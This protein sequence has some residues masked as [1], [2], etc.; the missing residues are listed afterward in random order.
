MWKLLRPL[1]ERGVAIPASPVPAGAQGCCLSLQSSAG[2]AP[3]ALQG[4][5]AITT[6]TGA[7]V[8]TIPVATSLALG[9][10]ASGKPTAIHQL[11][12]NGGL[13]KL[14]S[15]LPGLAQI[16]NQATGEQQGSVPKVPPDLG[17][18]LPEQPL[19]GEG[20]AWF[21]GGLSDIFCVLCR[22]EGPDHH[23]GDT[24]GTAWPCGHPEP[25]Q[26]EHSAAPAG[27]AAPGPS[28]K[29]DTFQG[30]PFL[31]SVTLLGVRAVLGAEQ[32]VS[33]ARAVSLLCLFRFDWP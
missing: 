7:V 18:L 3:A 19:Q 22:P 9:A 14:A 28:G 1:L 31:G 8:R 5:A 23:H 24:E 17:L 20:P 21:G 25:A 6:D 12:T 15:S 11:L 2:K 33:G 29:G 13:A 30:T 32:G 26:P 27:G 16:S 4:L 10:S